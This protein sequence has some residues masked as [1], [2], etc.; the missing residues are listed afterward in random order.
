MSVNLSAIFKFLITTTSGILIG[1]AILIVL[2]FGLFREE[3]LF[4]L[5][6]FVI[7]LVV[8]GIILGFVYLLL[9]Y[10]K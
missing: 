7:F 5:M 6:Y 10:K 9:K 1:G 3:L 4:K 8:A 2:I